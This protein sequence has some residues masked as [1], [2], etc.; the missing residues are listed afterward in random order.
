MPTTAASCAT[1]SSV[2]WLYPSSIHGKPSQIYVRPISVATHTA[3]AR[4]TAPR[5]NVSHSRLTMAANA[6]GNRDKYKTR[7]N[8]AKIASALD[9]P[10]N[11][12]MVATSQ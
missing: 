11:V 4:S 2:T 3:G 5:P 7:R 1:G 12:T 10:P 6:A 8:A 9:N